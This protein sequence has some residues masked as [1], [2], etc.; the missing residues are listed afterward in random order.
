MT[1][2][3]RKL[4]LGRCTIRAVSI[5]WPFGNRS[6]RNRRAEH[7]QALQKLVGWGYLKYVP[8]EEQERVKEELLA[9]MERGVVDSAW[10]ADGVA[11]DRRSYP[12][13]MEALAHGGI[14][15]VLLMMNDV[16]V[17]EGVRLE[18]VVDDFQIVDDE[19][20]YDMVINGEHFGVDRGADDDNLRRIALQALLQIVARLLEKAGSQEGP[21][22]IFRDHA[23]RV[24]FLSWEMREYLYSLPGIQL[25][26]IS[27]GDLYA[28]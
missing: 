4:F 5:M 3:V 17:A 8:A 26:W 19:V 28:C 21:V 14:G 16:L 22:V 6:D 23:V 20:R 24:M 25:R 13:D 10:G 18:S 9:A 15:K 2:H 7:L 1:A 11:H 12:L 27:A